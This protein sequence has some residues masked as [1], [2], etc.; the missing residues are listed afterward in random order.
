M[1][2]ITL[3]KVRDALLYEQFEINLSEDIIQRGKK[4]VNR[5]LEISYG[6]K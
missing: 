5:M 1:K 2:K 3:E 4:S 6:K